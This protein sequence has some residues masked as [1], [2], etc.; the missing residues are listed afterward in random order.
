VFS[1]ELPTV[2]LRDVHFAQHCLTAHQQETNEG[3]ADTCRVLSVFSH[4]TLMLTTQ[5]CRDG[6]PLP[7]VRFLGHS[8]P[9]IKDIRY[10][11]CQHSG[12]PKAN[13][14][15][16]HFFRMSVIKVSIKE[17]TVRFLWI[18]FPTS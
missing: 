13:E 10:E 2:F 11:S 8:S 4:K 18:L 15:N 1:A 17:I 6:R 7:P 3:E 12:D 16:V 14:N 9:S 5:S